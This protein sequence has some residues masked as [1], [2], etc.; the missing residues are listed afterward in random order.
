MDK[1]RHIIFDCFGTLIDT[2]DYSIKAVKRILQSVGSCVDAEEFYSLWKNIKREMANNVEFMN[3][4]RLFSLSLGA[5]FEKYGIDADAEK[6]VG[7]MIDALYSER[8]VFPEVKEALFE[9]AGKGY[10][11]AIGSTTDT[12]S[13]MN[14]LLMNELSFERVYTSESM[15]V[16]KPSELFYRTILQRSGWRAE[17]CI[18]VGDNYIDD[19]WGPKMIG[20]KA[21][22]LDRYRKYDEETLMPKP[23]FVL[24]SLS[25]LVN[26][27]IKN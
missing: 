19:V 10:D 17:E 13:I 26:F 2:K 24:R 1:L 3:E 9:L 14:C 27:F 7:P 21:V 8:K 25:D 6:E 22:L 23:D 4:K 5:V 12:D 15:E 18:F 16:Y 20:M 11:F